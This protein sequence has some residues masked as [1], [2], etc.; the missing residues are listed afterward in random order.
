MIAYSLVF[1]LRIFGLVRPTRSVFLPWE[2]V[3]CNGSILRCSIPVTKRE[4]TCTVLLPSRIKDG[5]YIILLEFIPLHHVI[6][7]NALLYS[8]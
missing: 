7:L 6:F 3:L 8:L 4:P 1:L 5:V 2:E